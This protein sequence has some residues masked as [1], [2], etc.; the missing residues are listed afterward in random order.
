MSVF[1]KRVLRKIF[2]PKRDELIGEWREL[3]NEKLNYLYSLPN[4]VGVIK[5]RR[6]SWGGEG[7]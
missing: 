7:I 3:H 2:V 4:V 6:L 5:S 1:E